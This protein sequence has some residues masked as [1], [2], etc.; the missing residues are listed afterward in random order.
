MLACVVSGGQTGVDRAALD[1]AMAV[2]IPCGGWCPA[3]RR[4]EDGRIPPQYPLQETDAR[5]YA[6]RTRLNVRDSDGTLILVLNEISNGTRLTIDA[7]R[8]EQKPCLVEYLLPEKSA[9]LVVA[10]NSTEQQLATVVDWMR[11]HRIRILNVAGP[12]GSSD[13]SVYP[14]ARAFLAQL[15]EQLNSPAIDQSA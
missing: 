7:A 2:G 5:S 15:L 12:R 4:S 8:Q 11:R 3:G 9:G 14:L 10:E 1:A 6:V 13:S